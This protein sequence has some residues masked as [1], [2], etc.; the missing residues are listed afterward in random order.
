MQ[1]L[2]ARKADI[3]KIWVDDRDHKFTKLS[4][5]L[6]TAVIDEAHKNKLR[7][8]AH[9]FALEDAKG[10]LKAGIDAFAHGIRDTDADAEVMA[11]FK[12]H[13][14][15][16]VVPN[17]PDRGV[18]ADYSWLRGHIPDGELQKIQAAATD[19]PQVAATW[20]IQGRNL[21][22]LSAAGVRIALG[23]DGNTPWAPHVEMA[24][25]VAA[26]MTPAQVIVASTRN[27][28]AFIRLPNTGTIEAGKT[29][30]LLVLDANPLDDI[31]NTRR[32]SAVYLRGVAVDRSTR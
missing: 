31:T 10:L 21:A 12:A 16:V 32:I 24:D 15:V 1:E 30:D 18:A 5:A 28:A 7:V 22:K 2:A 19:R 4:P 14:N 23:T 25:M 26:G 20:A 27:S 6:Y 3:V 29:A 17:M 9:I 11:L 8:T 13:P